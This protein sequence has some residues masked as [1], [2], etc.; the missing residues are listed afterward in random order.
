M[1]DA[2]ARYRRECRLRKALYNQL[3][4]LRGNIRVFARVRPLSS[5]ESAAAAPGRDAAAVLLPPGASAP[6]R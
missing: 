4:E 1:Q 5:S 6:A 2:V 3:I